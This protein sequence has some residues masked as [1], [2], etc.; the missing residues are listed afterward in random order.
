MEKNVNKEKT[1]RTIQY[2]LRILLIT[3]ISIIFGLSIY[4]WNAKSLRGDVFPMPFNIG[5][6]VVMT[7]SM[8][9]NITPDD[10]I[11]VK[12]TND[13]K[14]DEVIVYQ[15]HGLLVVHRIIEINGDEIITQGDANNTPD[16][17]IK[18]DQVKGE[19]IK[20]YPGIGL[21]VK[22]IKTPAGIFVILGSA[23]LLLALSYRKE[24]E[25]K[26]SELNSIKEEILKLKK[27]IEQQ[28][29]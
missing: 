4:T 9:P 6:G 21:V 8:E 3:F 1:K 24:K 10:L 28:N 22:L 7:G 15:S 29:K 27:E 5:I 14:V 25:E 12:K 17:P 26:S 16:D 23:V 13:Y 2:A 20:V 18:V 19:V 11:I